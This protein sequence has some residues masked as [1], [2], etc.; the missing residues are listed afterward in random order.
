[1]TLYNQKV[2]FSGTSSGH[3]GGILV[4]FEFGVFNSIE[5]IF[6]IPLFKYIWNNSMSLLIFSL[7]LLIPPYLFNRVMLFKDNRYLNYYEIFKKLSDRKKKRYE[8]V[9]FF[10]FF[11]I[12]IF[13]LS[14]FNF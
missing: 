11:F 7:L 1:M 9:C 2:I 10:T 5:T 14:S 8:T 13:F 12:L 6:K 3:L 4:L